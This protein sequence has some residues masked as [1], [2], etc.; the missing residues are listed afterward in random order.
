MSRLAH[1]IPESRQC[2]KNRMDIGS[3]ANHR[4]VLQHTGVSAWANLKSKVG[5][6][7]ALRAGSTSFSIDG[8]SATLD[9]PY[10]TATSW[11]RPSLLV[12]SHYFVE[13]QVEFDN[14]TY[15][16]SMKELSNGQSRLEVVLF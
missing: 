12:A 16:H 10:R 3:K 6:I 2:L 13:D 4:H 1:P 8:G 14:V 7:K 9:P 15:S 11:L 5:W